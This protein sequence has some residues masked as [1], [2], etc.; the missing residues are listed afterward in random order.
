M[1]RKVASASDACNAPRMTC[2]SGQGTIHCGAVVSISAFIAT[3]GGP[4][5]KRKLAITS[6]PIEIPYVKDR[7]RR[8]HRPAPAVSG[9]AGAACC[10]ADGK[11]GQGGGPARADA[12]RDLGHC[13][14]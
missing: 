1:S 4:L 3:V 6:I 13:V 5:Y 12:A 2:P 11:H 7:V 10:R 14:R 8:A 9:S